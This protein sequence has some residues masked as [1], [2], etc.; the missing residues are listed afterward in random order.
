METPF[1]LGAPGLTRTGPAR[2]L[3]SRRTPRLLLGAR[4]P[5]NEAATGLSLPARHPA[6]LFALLG[7][8]SRL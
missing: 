4:R 5:L 7:A 3:A 1:L 6:R 8:T 2:P